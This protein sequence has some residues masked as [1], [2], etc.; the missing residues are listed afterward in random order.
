MALADWQIGGGAGSYTIVVDVTSPGTNT[1][2]A[3][4][5]SDIGFRNTTVGNILDSRISS[6]IKAQTYIGAGFSTR[7]GMRLRTSDVETDGYGNGFELGI[8]LNGANFNVSL[9]QHRIGAETILATAT[10]PPSVGTNIDWQL[11]RFSAFSVG[12]ITYLRGELWNG[13]AFVPILDTATTNNFLATTAGKA[14]FFS[15]NTSASSHIRF[16]DVKIYTLT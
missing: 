10:I 2:V 6:Y 14:Y 3:D 8:A 16:D 4:L 15:R 11:W 5:Q 1:D 13:A 12:D 9:A 7:Y